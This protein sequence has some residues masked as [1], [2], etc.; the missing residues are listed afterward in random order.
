MSDRYPPLTKCP[1]MLH[2]GDYNPDQWDRET[3]A[4]DMRLMKL[5]GCNAM[6]V[7]IFSW[8]HLE[9]ADGQYEFGWLDEIMDMLAAND[10]YAVLATPSASHPTW[11]SQK[12]P[13]V[14]R[15][16]ADLRRRHH[17]G[18]VNFCLTSPVFRAEGGRHR[19]KAG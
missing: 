17:G 10:A 15:V 14:L 2:G 3:W 7:G 8:A 6:S 18:R 4:E 5:A 16:D 1:H 19:R 13:E 9:V 12:Y 11:M